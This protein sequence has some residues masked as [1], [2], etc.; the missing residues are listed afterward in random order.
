[1]ISI[2]VAITELDYVGDHPRAYGPAKVI[3]W[4]A[5]AGV[6]LSGAVGLICVAMLKAASSTT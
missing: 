3:A 5:G 1:M 4:G 6:L 2:G